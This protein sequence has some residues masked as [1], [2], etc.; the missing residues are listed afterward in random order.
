M[1]DQPLPE[2]L[3]PL[4]W[5]TDFDRLRIAGHERYIIERVLKL[6]D[7]PEVRWMMRR[8][9][10]EQIVDALCR[11]RGLTRKSA[12]FWALVLDIPPESVR[13]LA[14]SSRR[15]PERIWPW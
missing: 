14:T 12:R 4:F 7:L 2:F 13:C 5:D 11:S 8:F 6:G 15:R 10:R 1:A 3:R 9:P